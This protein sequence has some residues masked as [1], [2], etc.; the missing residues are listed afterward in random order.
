MGCFV[1]TNN[2]DTSDATATASTILNGYTA[3]VAS[4]KITG[5]YVAPSASFRVIDNRVSTSG[6]FCVGLFNCTDK[7]I[8]TQLR[9][10]LSGTKTGTVYGLG[11]FELPASTAGAVILY[12]STNLILY[13]AFG[14]QWE[15]T[16]DYYMNLSN[17]GSW[18]QFM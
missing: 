10:S 15:L 18:I 6:D 4:G 7:T 9:L 11:T 5:S 2:I 13:D 16:P 8:T 17:S 3:Y 14:G 12:P 1:P